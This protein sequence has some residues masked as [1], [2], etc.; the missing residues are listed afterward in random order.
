[1]RLDGGGVP[2][3]RFFQYAAQVTK[4]FANYRNIADPA[5]FVFGSGPELLEAGVYQSFGADPPSGAMAAVRTATAAA[6]TS[7]RLAELAASRAEALAAAA[8]APWPQAC[9]R[10]SS[11]RRWS[12]A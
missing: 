12:A 2:W 3:L 1:M 6:G 11:G 5:G 4:Y 7:Q 8:E 9:A 10:T